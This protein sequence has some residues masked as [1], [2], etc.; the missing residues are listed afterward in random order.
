MSKKGGPAT[1]KEALLD[2]LSADD[3]LLLMKF[4]CSF[5]WAD[6]NI[7]EQERAFVAAMVCRLELDDVESR[8]IHQW[9]EVPPRADEVDP[10][11]V[12][13]QHREIFLKAVRATVAVDGEISPEEQ[14]NMK[15]FDRLIA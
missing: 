6:L 11:H 5:A 10:S 4:V 9:L 12:P 3:R 7:N 8:Q 14:E 1:E 2:R 13:R 15:L